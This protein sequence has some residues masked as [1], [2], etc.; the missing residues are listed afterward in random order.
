V[1]FAFPTLPGIAPYLWPNPLELSP[2]APTDQRRFWNQRNAENHVTHLHEV[3]RRQGEIVGKWLKDLGR[4][5]LQ[6]IELG[7]GAAWFTPSPASLGSV[8]GT[9]L[10]DELL[11]KGSGS[12]PGNQIC[13]RRLHDPRLRRRSL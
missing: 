1:R 8:T 10:S 9:D 5:D 13:R 12:S 2:A 11:G 4:T 7:C 6:I 3:S